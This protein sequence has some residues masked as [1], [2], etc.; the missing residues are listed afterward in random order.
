M[1]QPI[2]KPCPSQICIPLVDN[3]LGVAVLHAL[4]EYNGHH[5]PRVSGPHACHSDGTSSSDGLLEDL[6]LGF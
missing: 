6:V 1:K 2:L 5:Q 3:K 4:A